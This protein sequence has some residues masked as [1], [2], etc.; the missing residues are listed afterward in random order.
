M[1]SVSGVYRTKK[2]RTFESSSRFVDFDFHFFN[3]TK[4]RLKF[5][6]FSTFFDFHFFCSLFFIDFYRLFHQK[7]KSRSTILI[8]CN[9]VLV[10]GAK[11]SAVKS[12]V[13]T[14]VTVGLVAL[15]LALQIQLADFF[16]QHMSYFISILE[17]SNIQLPRCRSSSF[18]WVVQ[19]LNSERYL[20]LSNFL[21]M[22]FTHGI[23]HFCYR[24]ALPFDG[25]FLFDKHSS[26]PE[27]F[28]RAVSVTGSTIFHFVLLVVI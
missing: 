10:A 23:F 12:Q 20:Y 21:K 13:Q 7:S 6:F 25:L 16:L 19:Y 22:L 27:I 9:P 24:S 26:F 17:I 1:V 14:T 8:F 18:S 2:S 28:E 3:P 4:S 15:A 11:C 5:D